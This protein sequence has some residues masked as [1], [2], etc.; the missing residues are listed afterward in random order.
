MASA[1]DNK[2]LYYH[3]QTPFLGAVRHQL[4]NSVVL[5]P[6]CSNSDLDKQIFMQFF[7]MYVIQQIIDY[8]EFLIKLDKLNNTQTINSALIQVNLL[9]CLLH[10]FW[11]DYIAL[12][13]VRFML[14]YG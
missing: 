6:S 8:N 2:L 10:N 1:S 5:F 12:H 13:S 4:I 11:L 3:F 9:I 7:L 14:C